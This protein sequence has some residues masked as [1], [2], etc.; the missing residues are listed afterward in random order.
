MCSGREARIESTE[1]EEE[2]SMTHDIEKFRNV[3]TDNLVDTYDGLQ[4]PVEIGPSF[5]YV[6]ELTVEKPTRFPKTLTETQSLE[7]RFST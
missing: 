2:N 7:S 1:L 4:T 6:P 5:V 3:S